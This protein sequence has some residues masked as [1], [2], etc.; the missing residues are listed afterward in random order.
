[1]AELVPDAHLAILCVLPECGV[2][3]TAG[4]A[5]HL[6]QPV[7]CGAPTLTPEVYH[8]AISA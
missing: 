1:M 6:P 4:T 7:D 2:L 8:A 5:A 3:A